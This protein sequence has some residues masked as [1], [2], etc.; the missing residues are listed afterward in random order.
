MVIRYIIAVQGICSSQRERFYNWIGNFTRLLYAIIVTWFFVKRL[1]YIITILTLKRYTL[2]CAAVE[3]RCG[4]GLGT[5]GCAPHT[6]SRDRTTLQCGEY[7][8]YLSFT[9]TIVLKLVRRGVVHDVK[10]RVVALVALEP[11]V[12]LRSQNVPPH[13]PLLWSSIR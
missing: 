8:S 1:I 10:V 13:I 6:W 9:E 3:K 7:W 12:R 5:G 11:R 2:S 4:S